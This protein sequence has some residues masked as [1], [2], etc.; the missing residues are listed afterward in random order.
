MK[1][2]LPS[3]NPRTHLPNLTTLQTR[4]TPGGEFYRSVEEAARR[5]QALI[6]Q[7]DERRAST[8]AGLQARRAVLR[9][10]AALRT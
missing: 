2:N 9:P 5:K 8:R 1:F 3:N 6:A 10:A 4:S 7:M